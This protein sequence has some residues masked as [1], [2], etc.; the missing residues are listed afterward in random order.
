MRRYELMVIVSDTLDEEGVEV[1]WQRVR[2]LVADQ[3]G[4]LVDE[5]VWGR[6]QFTYE[7]DHRTHGHY[8]VFDLE[9]GLEG[10][11]E[12]ERQLKLADDVVRFKALRPGLRVR[13]PA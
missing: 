8:A 2:D 5:N 1:A 13:R 6:R 3:G 7:I 4:R 9:I 10:K 12:L 11:A